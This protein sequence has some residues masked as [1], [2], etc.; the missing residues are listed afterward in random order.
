MQQKVR[1]EVTDAKCG[2]Q[3]R[4]D[5]TGA[6]EVRGDLGGGEEEMFTT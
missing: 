2:F 4:G 6:L 3:K 1:G 5:K